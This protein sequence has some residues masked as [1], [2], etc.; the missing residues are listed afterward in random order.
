MTLSLVDL[1]GDREVR[2][3]TIVVRSGETLR[4]GAGGEP[5]PA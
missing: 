3:L 4:P 1:T 5:A 2:D